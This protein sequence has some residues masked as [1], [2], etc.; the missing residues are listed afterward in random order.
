MWKDSPLNVS[1]PAK[2]GVLGT[3]S[4]PEPE[5]MILAVSCS[6]DSVTT[7]HLLVTLSQV[8]A[9]ILSPNLMFGVTPNLK[10]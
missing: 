1:A 4:A 10:G 9:R 6:P 3:C 2:S 5:M 7:L 8:L